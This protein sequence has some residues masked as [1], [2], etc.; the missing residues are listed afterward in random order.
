MQ[1]KIQRYRRIMARQSGFYWGMD[2]QPGI[3][4]VR[5]EAPRGSR[6]S[7]LLSARL[8]RVIHVLSTI[9]RVFAQFALF[10]PCLFELHEQRMLHPI[11]AVH[12]LHGHPLA[13]GMDLAPVLGTVE[14]A[15]AFN[16]G[17]DWVSLVD[18]HGEPYVAPYPFLGDLLLFL[19][20][21]DGQPYCV[22][23]TIK[24]DRE[25]FSE[26]NRTS[27]KSLEAQKRDRDKAALRQQIEREHYRAAGIRTI[28]LSR[29]DLDKEFRLNLNFLFSWHGAPAISDESLGA[30]FDEEIKV[31]VMA[32]QPVNETIKRYSSRWG[33]Q[34]EFLARLYQSIWERKLLVDMFSPIL[35]DSPFSTEFKDALDHYEHFFTE[36][37]SEDW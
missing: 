2:Y 23:W 30:E 22:N 10:H 17:H 25:D 11:S 5:G 16:C 31:A 18:G 1:S 27:L 29:D 37:E 12:P 20:N 6:P 3:R 13:V 8:R 15:Q 28:E 36:V 26:K 32:G 7:Q 9:E 19:R 34:H 4:A 14:I 21:A 24:L 33:R 35:I